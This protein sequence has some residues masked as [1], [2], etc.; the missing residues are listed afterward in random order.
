MAIKEARRQGYYVKDHHDLSRLHSAYNPLSEAQKLF[1]KKLPVHENFIVAGAGLGYLLQLIG[2]KCDKPRAAIFEPHPELLQKG[3]ELGIWEK[4]CFKQLEIFSPETEELLNRLGEFIPLEEHNRFKLIEWPD[5]QRKKPEVFQ[6]FLA[7]LK[8]L[9]T[10]HEISL[11]TL[12]STGKTWLNNLRENIKLLPELKIPRFDQFTAKIALVGAGPSLDKQLEWLRTNREQLLV[13]AVNTAGP[14]LKKRGIQADLHVAVDAKEIIREDLQHSNVSRLLLSPFVPPE[15]GH[16]TEVPVSLFGLQSPLTGWLTTAPF[17]PR[18]NAGGS[19]TTTSLNLLLQTPAEKIY[20]LGGDME[21]KGQW[22]YARGTWRE[23]KLLQSVNRFQPFAQAVIEWQ[24]EVKNL[25]K[26][27]NPRLKDEREWFNQLSQQKERLAIPPPVPSWWEGKLAPDSL[28][29]NKRTELKFTNLSK[30][31]LKKWLTTQLKQL[32]SC[33]P[34]DR[35]QT[36]WEKFYFWLENITD[37]PGEEF[38]RW[39]DL[40]EEIFY[41]V[42]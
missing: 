41:R 12:Q 27:E 38:S 32:R 26:E 9:Q 3:L 34:S 7:S 15:I 42:S 20:L 4:E 16:F 17:L 39:Q 2:Q 28:S 31:Q 25:N 19:V 29:G 35:P 14:V 23:E 10:F 6:P 33:S 8:Q 36:E 18:A 40:L 24:K 1:P 13:I 22:Y 21:F 5:Y 11:R 30:N 37:N